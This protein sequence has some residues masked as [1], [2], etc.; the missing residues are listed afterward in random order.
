METELCFASDATRTSA[1][2]LGLRG[3]PCAY[4]DQTMST[5][6]KQVVILG[7]DFAGVYTA[8]CLEKLLRSE[9][10]SITLINRGNY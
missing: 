3:N 2:R 9:E 10:A 4:F 5:G 1:K 8:R 6:P 7:G